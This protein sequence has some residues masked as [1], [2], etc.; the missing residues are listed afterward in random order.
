MSVKTS[1]PIIHADVC[2]CVDCE[3]KKAAVAV[4]TESAVLAHPKLVGFNQTKK[5]TVKVATET[6][7]ALSKELFE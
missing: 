3:A 6:T 4:P 7:I 5:E 1:S 2:E